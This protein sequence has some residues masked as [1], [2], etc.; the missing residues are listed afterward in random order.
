MIAK[1]FGDLHKA[2]ERYKELEAQKEDRAKWEK[3]LKDAKRAD[4]VRTFIES[5]EASA[6]SLQK[7]KK[8]EETA[9]ETADAKKKISEEA[10][11]KVKLHA[12][13]EKDIEDLKSKKI[14]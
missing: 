8:E 1:R 12:E 6:E 10:S 13:K 5:E 3:S 9:R 14:T 11:E 2:E 7:R 4:K